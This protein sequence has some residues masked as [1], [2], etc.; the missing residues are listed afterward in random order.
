[1]LFRFFSFVIDRLSCWISSQV[2]WELLL[3]HNFCLNVCEHINLCVYLFFE[4][5]V[6]VPIFLVNQCQ[7]KSVEHFRLFSYRLWFRINSLHKVFQS[8]LISVVFFHIF[9]ARKLNTNRTKN[10]YSLEYCDKKATHRTKGRYLLLL[11][12]TPS[13]SFQIVCIL[14]CMID[15]FILTID[16]MNWINIRWVHKWMW[17]NNIQHS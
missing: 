6:F 17:N 10:I 15:T 16:T 7:I 5:L 14:S 12:K 4:I 13:N 3:A 11:I 1:M 9:V 2:G 8:I